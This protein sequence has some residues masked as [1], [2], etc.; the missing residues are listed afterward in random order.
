M[1]IPKPY[2]KNIPQIG[3]IELDY[4][5]LE[6]GFPVL[7]TCKNEEKLFLCICRNVV[8][9]QEWTIS[10]IDF[11][12]LSD[13]INNKITIKQA[14]QNDKK[15]YCLATW[16]KKSISEEY[17]VIKGEYLE[18]EYLP[19]DNIYLEDNEAETIEYLEKVKNRELL[20]KEKYL[21]K[22]IGQYLEGM[23]ATVSFKTTKIKSQ[24]NDQNISYK[25]NLTSQSCVDI[26]YSEKLFSKSTKLNVSKNQNT[27]SAA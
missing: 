10:E 12:V 14:M 11:D 21:Q 7:F 22:L 24:S 27:C 13:L 3:D 6:N 9:Q 19:E 26:N 17:T 16:S 15:I 8:D 20:K 18:D 2:F 23:V 5:F 25:N 1:Y 4:I